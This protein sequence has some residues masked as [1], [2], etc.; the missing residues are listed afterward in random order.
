MVTVT[1]WWPQHLPAWIQDFPGAA[2]VKPKGGAPTYY[3]AKFGPKLHE[4]EEN[5][6]RGTRLK[7]YCVDPPLFTFPPLLV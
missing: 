4:N 7:F 3:L 6:T 2:D 1:I 5:W